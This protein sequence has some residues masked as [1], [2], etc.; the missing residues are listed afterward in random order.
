M[1]IKHFASNSGSDLCFFTLDLKLWPWSWH[2]IIQ[3]SYQ[4]VSQIFDSLHVSHVSA[5]SDVDQ[6]TWPLTLDDDNDLDI[7][8]L[9]F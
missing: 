4:Y 6:S 8:I 1:F 3:V 9:T 7:N 5:N 2:K